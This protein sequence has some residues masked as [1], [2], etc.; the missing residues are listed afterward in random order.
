MTNT[1]ADTPPAAPGTAV[2]PPPAARS[3]AVQFTAA[4]I[5][6]FSDL[7]RRLGQAY[8]PDADRPLRQDLVDALNAFVQL[9]PE[10]SDEDGAAYLAAMR[11]G[12]LPNWGMDDQPLTETTEEWAARVRAAQAPS[13]DA[14]TT[15]TFPGLPEFVSA[16]RVWVAGFLPG[17]PAAA[18]AAL[19]T[20]ELVTNAILH[21]ASGLPGGTVTVSVLAVDGCVRVGVTDQGET[22]GCTAARGGLGMG[23]VIVSQLADTFG[24]DGTD[25]WFWLRTRDGAR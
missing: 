22:P 24:A 4:Q 7:V 5:F 14:V 12:D 19:M 20:S 6:G 13:P 25:R 9:L 15:R 18:D 8:G 11:A 1:T 3:Y 16:A 10:P 2:G 17:S 23:L 21:S